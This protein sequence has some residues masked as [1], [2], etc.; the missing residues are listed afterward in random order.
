VRERFVTVNVIVPLRLE[1]S[2]DELM[3]TYPFLFV[4]AV[5][6]PETRPLTATFTV[7]LGTALP[8]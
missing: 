3:V 2:R 1:E 5:A 8:L 7:A 4:V 6:V